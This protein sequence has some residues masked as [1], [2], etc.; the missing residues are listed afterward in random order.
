M[1]PTIPK[2]TRDYHPEIV[3]KRNYIID[4]ITDVFT[5][6]GY[7][8]IQTPSFEKRETLSGKYGNE[9]DRL[10]FNIVHFLFKHVYTCVQTKYY[11]YTLF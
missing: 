11:S 1:K 7:L 6:Y 4:I 2:G 3:L 9:G 8:E 10:I 5:K